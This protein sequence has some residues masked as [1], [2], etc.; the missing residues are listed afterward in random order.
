[1]APF[2]NLLKLLNFDCHADPDPAFHSIADWDPAFHNNAY[3]C[4]SGSAALIRRHGNNEYGSVIL[5]ILSIYYEIVIELIQTN[6]NM[7]PVSRLI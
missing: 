4:E 6:L 2:L 7:E 3:P 1:M 5:Q